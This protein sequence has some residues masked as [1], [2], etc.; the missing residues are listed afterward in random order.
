ML[1]HAVRFLSQFCVCC[2]I[3]VTKFAHLAQLP[4]PV[5]FNLSCMFVVV[6]QVHLAANTNL[7][8][9]HT[10]DM[11]HSKV[12]DNLLACCSHLVMLVR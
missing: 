1:Q 10:I 11:H 2:E 7:L 8:G 4:L 9:F 6:A 5:L 3:F 12:D